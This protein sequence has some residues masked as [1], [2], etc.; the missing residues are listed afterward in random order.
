VGHLEEIVGIVFN[1]YDIWEENIIR[2]RSRDDWNAYRTQ[3]RYCRLPVSAV[4]LMSGAMFV[5]IG[6]VQVLRTAYATS[7]ILADGNGVKNVGPG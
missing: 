4:R 7:R 3:H 6:A 5:S 2:I 1:D